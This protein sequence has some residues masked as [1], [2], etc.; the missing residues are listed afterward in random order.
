MSEFIAP[1]SLVGSPGA[2]DCV[3]GP[4]VEPEPVQ[5]WAAAASS[6]RHTHSEAVWN[7]R[8]NLAGIGG[9][10]SG[11]QGRSRHVQSCICTTAAPP[12]SLRQAGCPPDS[13]V[14]R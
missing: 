9:A 6:S 13:A 14:L 8:R 10:F 4:V 3:V 5:A 11:A 2:T 12:A 1:A 7:N